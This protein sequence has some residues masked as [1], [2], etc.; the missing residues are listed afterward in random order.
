MG[1]ASARH[2]LRPLLVEGSDHGSLG[3]EMRREKDNV[4]LPVIARSDSDE[5]IQTASDERSLDCFASLAM[6]APLQVR[7]TT[8]RIYV[9]P[10]SGTAT[11]ITR[12]CT[13]STP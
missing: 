2:S 12:S 5:A 7:A 8:H 11:S 10:L 1:A 3:R 13:R 9:G 6:T 4:C